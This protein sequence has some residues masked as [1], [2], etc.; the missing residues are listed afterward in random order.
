MIGS[1]SRRFTL[2]FP[3]FGVIIAVTKYSLF[4]RKNVKDTD[5][6][7][8]SILP[9]LIKFMFPVLVAMFLQATYGAVDLLVVGQF[10]TPADVSGVSTGS[11]IIMTLTNLVIGLAMGI[12]VDVAQRVGEKRP[13]AA[14]ESIG[15]GLVLFA[16][17]G[18]IFSA[19]CLVLAVPMA[20]LLNA[21]EEA[22][23]IT[24]DYIR[25]CG[26][27]FLVITAYNLLGSIF[28]GLGD[29]KT[30]LIAVGIACACNVV[31]DLLL[32]AVF[33]LGAAGAAIA[34]VLAQLISVAISLV[35]IR[36]AELPFQL[37]RTE[38]RLKKACVRT[39]FRIGIPI[40]LQDFLV[41]ISFLVLLAIV[42]SLGLE[43]SAGVGVAEKV[44]AFIMLVPSAFMH[45]M[46]SFVAQNI[47]A[48]RPDRAKQA[49]KGGIAVSFVFGVV[50]FLLTFFAGN[51]L[52]GIFSRDASTVMNA[53]SY[54]KA[55]A[56]D[57]LLTC[58]LF[59]FMGYYNGIERTRFVMLQ[60]I[61]GAFCIRIPVVFLM[62]RFGGGS[63]F[64]IGL[65][66]PCSTVVQIVLCFIEYALLRRQEVG[67]S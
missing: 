43:A 19:I 63:L 60:G 38:I 4:G 11:Q 14:A 42:N 47:G 40:A 53:W 54:L 3:A 67:K 62:Q 49:L 22:L 9:H 1:G 46:S 39:I 20:E 16:I 7:Q 5:F 50:M 51:L 52:A 27:G 48:G 21:P 45:S 30:P 41:G 57:C 26:G 37:T 35:I 65:A 15:T 64:L 23:G 58:F 61:C 2:S 66:T 55:Y 32:V 12:T 36:R 8:G 13:E 25:I 24:A 28:R 34:T 10:G 33:H 59:C 29:S 56:I 17:V 44:C 31:G 18:A 6:T